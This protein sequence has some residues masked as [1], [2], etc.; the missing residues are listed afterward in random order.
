[1]A[2]SAKLQMVALAA[3]AVLT[4]DRA[5]AQREIEV[6]ERLDPAGLAAKFARSV[7]VGQTGDAQ[8]SRDIIRRALITLSP[9][10]GSAV[11][12]IINELT[13]AP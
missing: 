1:M 9:N 13:G 6:A 2:A 7:L 10:D 4:G 5:T 11:A 8:A 12:R 3:I